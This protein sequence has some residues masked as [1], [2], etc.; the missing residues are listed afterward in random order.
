MTAPLAE[1]ITAEAD[2]LARH[3][4]ANYVVQ[5]ILQYGRQEHR[6]Q[7]INAMINGDITMLAQ[8]RVASNVVERALDQ[9][10]LEGQRA[11]ANALLMVPPTLLLMSCSRYGSYA[12]RRLLDV[13]SGPLHDQA[14]CQLAAGFV[15]LKTSKYG[16]QLAEKVHVCVAQK[17]FFL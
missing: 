3:P 14:I 6:T 12:V 15:Q 2:V 17:G 13:I 9:G 16:K 8:H 5:H 1:A 7:V 10:N 11:I 4:F